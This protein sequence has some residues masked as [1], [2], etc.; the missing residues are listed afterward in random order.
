MAIAWLIVL[1]A[2]WWLLTSWALTALT[3][4]LHHQ[5]WAAI[6]EMSFGTALLVTLLLNAV[7]SPLGRGGSK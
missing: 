3:S 7:L 2:I 5:W 1:L 4:V 6:P